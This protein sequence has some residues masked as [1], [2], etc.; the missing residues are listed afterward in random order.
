LAN[1]INISLLGYDTEYAVVYLDKH[2][3][4]A[5]T[6]SACSGAGGGESKVVRIMT[7]DEK[8]AKSTLRLSLGVETKKSD[9]EKVIKVIQ[10]F[11]EKMSGLT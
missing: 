5:S 7:D 3:I 10:K 6:K 11:Q 9:L 2:G 1:N 4:S 8:R